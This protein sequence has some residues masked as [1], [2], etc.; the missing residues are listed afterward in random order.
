MDVAP[1]RFQR[2]IITRWLQIVPVLDR[3]VP[4]LPALTSYFQ[5]QAT[6]SQ[7][8]REP[9]LDR[10]QSIR[11]NLLDKSVICDLYFLQAALRDLQE[12][13]LLFQRVSI[14]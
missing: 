2:H 13:E 5:Q 8:S 6:L 9:T 12:F 1:L 4:Q 3:L 14:L 10:A 11:D 7:N